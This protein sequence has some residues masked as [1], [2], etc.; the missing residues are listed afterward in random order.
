MKKKRKMVGQELMEKLEKEEA[1]FDPDMYYEQQ[2]DE[3]MEA[4][5]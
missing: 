3:E 5:G 2:R 4:E 1:E